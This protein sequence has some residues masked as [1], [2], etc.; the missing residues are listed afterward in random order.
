MLLSLTN[1]KKPRQLFL[2]QAFCRALDFDE[3]L[4]PAWVT[5]A[6]IM[7]RSLLGHRGRKTRFQ[8]SKHF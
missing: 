7:L 2:K 6:V 1:L 8:A 5:D 3:R 4:F